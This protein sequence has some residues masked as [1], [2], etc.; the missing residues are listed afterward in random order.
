MRIATGWSTLADA[1]RA[2]A[3][4]FDMV[5]QRLQVAPDLLLV[6]ASCELDTHALLGHLASR[7]PNAQ[8]QGGTSCMGVLTGDGVHTQDG[9]GMGLLGLTDADGGY[10]VGLASIGDDPDTAA[11]TALEEALARAERPGEVPEVVL[12]SSS[13]GHEDQMIRAIESHIGGNVPIIGGTCADN[14]MSG[15]WRVFAG[16]Q[17]AAEGVS[18][19]TLF[20]TAEIGYSFHSGYEPTEYRGRVTRAEGRVLYEIDG[21][22]AARVYDEWSGGV[23]ADCL[24]VGG[25]LVPAASLTPLGNPVGQ[26]SGV[27]YYRLSYPVEVVENDALLLFTE[28]REG[29]ETVMMRGSRNS[30]A[31]RAGRVAAAAVS[32]APF[33]AEEVQG[34]LMLFCAGCML[35][36]QDRLEQSA[37]G[38]RASLGD[39]PFLTAFTLGEQGCFIGGENR[40]ANLMIASLVFGPIKEE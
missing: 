39:A 15:K 27:P 38:V 7:A 14:D 10:G 3:E 32:A 33:G 1:E 17:V 35:V 9:V 40:H 26:I 12:I 5:V 6:H 8:I 24:S 31:T 37:E 19:A 29:T 20:P 36:V 11:V 4:A 28:I 23:A 34:A 30:L 13:P 25:S 21:Q 22:P 18:V 16:D 2:A